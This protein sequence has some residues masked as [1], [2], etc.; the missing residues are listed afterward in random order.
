MSSKRIAV[1]GAPPRELRFSFDD[2]ALT[3]IEGDTIASALLANGVRVVG[4]SFKYHRPRGIFGAWSEEPNA[5]VDVALDGVHTPNVRATTH[6]LAEGMEVRSVNTGAGAE[7]DRN[8]LIDRFGQFLPAGFYYKTFLW[9][10]WHM[11][12]PRIR[13]MAGLGRLDP[14]TEPPADCPLISAHCDL[15]VVGA[16]PAGLAAARSA[17]AAGKRVM[18]VDDQDRLGGSLHH[19]GGV[20]DGLSGTEWAQAVAKDLTAAGH[21]VLTSTTAF[22]VYDHNLVALWQ[23]RS[24]APDALWHVRAK[25]I[26]LAA[27]AIERPLVFPDNDRPGVMSAEAALVYLRRHGV[28]VGGRIVL[29]TNNDMAYAAAAALREAGASV[30]VA[31]TR[32]SAETGADVRV[33]GR[34]EAVHGTGGVEAVTVGGER[35]E[36]D[37]LLVSGG[38][39]PTVHLFCQAG[40]KLRFDESI[41]AFVP[42]DPVAGIVVAGAANGRFSLSEVVAEG[43]RAGDGNGEAPKTD[44]EDERYGIEPAWPAPA[45]KA[46]QWVDFQNDVTVKDIELAARENFRSVEHL[47]RYTTLGM[48]TD[49]GKTSNM[50]GLAAMA[51]ITG[52]TIAETGTTTY[53]PPFV[54]VPFTVVAGRRRGEFFNPVRRLVLENE[55]RAA[56]AVFREYGGW[57][58]PAWYGTSSG[59]DEVAREARQARATAGILDGSPLGKIEVIGP[60]AGALVDYNSYQTISTLKPGRIRYGFMLTESGVIYDDGVVSKV[61]DEHYVV[62]CSSGHVPGV[63]ARLEEWRQD[64]FD[65]ARVF[66]HNST[67][68]WATLTATGPRSRDLVASLSLGVDLSDEALPHM[69]FSDGSFAGGPARVA[70][71]SFTGDRSYEVS[72]PSSRAKALNDAMQEAG[73]TLEAVTLGSEAL[74]MLRAEKGYIIAGKDTDGT[75][76]P[77]DLGVMG[78]RD[79]RKGEFVGKRSLFTEN[80]V[81]ED[82]PQGVGLTVPDGAPPLPTGAHA[83]ETAKGRRRSIGFVTSS[84]ESPSLGRPVALALVER[85]LSRMGE[86]IELFHLGVTMKATIAPVCAF[87]PEGARIN[88]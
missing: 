82:R 10:D 76:M 71:V 60:D 53:R 79:R 30:I 13:A 22:G 23:H 86:E 43:H 54:P 52:Q 49:Q 74:L 11:F 68:Q 9:P 61:S 77:H 44:T 27:G 16:G 48:A 31:D 42:G 33:G 67:P 73:R 21:S 81:R 63:V 12:E 15:L 80:A 87:D 3:G 18:L 4:R 66:I 26:V 58:R 24:G 2:K 29:A 35:I 40:G 84:Y 39:T 88:G 36:A 20:I 72:V 38:F 55:H 6:T 70:R 83:V 25:R 47:K 69:S 37:C 17:A 19:R 28:L 50:N 64:R 5:V 46:R 32:Q 59:A 51:A 41:A 78:P 8:A 1:S 34:I 57:L 7:R 62:S 14:A 65:R 75:T 85:G 45:G 56:G